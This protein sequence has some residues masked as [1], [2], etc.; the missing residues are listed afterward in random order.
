[1]RMKLRPTS[2]TNIRKSKTIISW[3]LSYAIVLIIPV[4]CNLFIYQK[5]VDTIKE[6]L[7]QSNNR[8]LTTLQTN[9]DDTISAISTLVMNISLNS[10]V[11]TLIT[12]PDDSAQT[13]YLLTQFAGELRSYRTYNANI[14]DIYLFFNNLDI[15][16]S[17]GY[18][19]LAKP[20]YDYFYSNGGI[21]YSDWYH[22]MHSNNY[23]SYYLVKNRNGDASIDFIFQLPLYSTNNTDVDASVVI[24]I[25]ESVLHSIVQRY[26]EFDDTSLY[27]L[28]SNNQVIMSYGNAGI[29]QENYQAYS[30][31]NNGMVDGKKA[32]T[33]YQT[34]PSTQWKYIS[35]IPD[36][37][38]DAQL[39]FMWLLNFINILICILVGGLLGYYFTLKNYRPIDRLAQFCENALSLNS[40]HSEMDLIDQMLQDYMDTKQEYKSIKN[41]QEL[42]HRTQ[43][44]TELCKGTF[45]DSVSLDEELL[46]HNISFI[47]PYFAV[48][49]FKISGYERLFANDETVD[50]QNRANMLIFIMRNVT[51]ELIG[52]YHR[53]YLAE[54]DGQLVCVVNFNEMRMAEMQEDMQEAIAKEK[55]FIEENFDFSFTC[56]MSAVHQ[57]IPG[58]T[59]AYHEA[60]QTLRFRTLLSQNEIVFYNAIN[61]EEQRM[62][63]SHFMT[64]EKERQLINLINLGDDKTAA[65][66]VDTLIEQHLQS[67]TIDTT[68]IFIFDLV[69]AIL[70]SIG[71][72]GSTEKTDAAYS[73]ISEETSAV[74]NFE[75]LQEFQENLHKLLRT[76]C[77]IKRHH[78]A[79]KEEKKHASEPN[80]DLVTN[81]KDYINKNYTNKLLNIATIGDY[82]NITPYYASN[83]FK[84]AEGESMLD[85]IGKL[86]VSVAKEIMHHDNSSMDVIAQQVGFSN[87]RTFMRAFSKYEGVTPGK[88]KE[89]LDA[90]K[91]K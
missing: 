48:L 89:L 39:H 65:R 58:I 17:S 86:R 11:E 22:E 49:L 21:A 16:V 84:K 50:D 76:V 3:L 8:M 59:E 37:V 90:E 66:V 9:M 83:I 78:L 31:S 15:G 20:F 43:L 12:M 74:L 10:N 47:S 1:M 7:Y 87:V 29:A 53:G 61:K 6:K 2:K 69:S 60:Q 88:Y 5:A 13:R 91:P 64:L 79:E 82:F 67:S 24:R 80:D 68:R 32:M 45:P 75:N 35:I 26:G 19:G 51:E 38:I 71:E 52:K 85:Y 28:D 54:I 57:G 34:S 46:R 42:S 72:D 25:D 63:K 33:I 70:K 18:Y 41:E 27:I 40:A 77:E 73:K 30:S 62:N 81:I 56:C 44:L 55:A 36:S 4:L 14:S 23:L